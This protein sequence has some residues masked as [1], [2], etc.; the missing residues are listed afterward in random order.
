M[1]CWCCG[2]QRY[3]LYSLCK[4]CIASEKEIILN[5]KT[6]IKKLLEEI[7]KYD[8]FVNHITPRELIDDAKGLL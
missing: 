1:E 8:T 3:T 7:D 5:Q 2:T 4:D 6:M